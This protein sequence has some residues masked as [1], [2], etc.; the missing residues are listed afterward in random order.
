M[1]QELNLRTDT[2]KIGEAL[3]F[4][5]DIS[6]FTELVHSTDAETGKEITREL[7]A[8]VITANSLQLKIA[9]IEGDA[10]LIYR[11]GQ[12]PSVSE[13]THQYEIMVRAFEEKRA[14]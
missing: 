2:S 9:E 11:H 10:I 4:I 7:P 1:V 14:E 3:I 12:A 5:P 8:S 13:L 6:G